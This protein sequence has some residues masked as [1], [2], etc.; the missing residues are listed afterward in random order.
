MAMKRL[1]R[2]DWMV[3]H[4]AATKTGQNVTVDDIRKWHKDRGFDDIGY[5]YYINFAGEVFDGRSIEFQGAHCPK[6]NDRSIGVCLEGGYGG[7]NNF[8]EEQMIAVVKLFEKQRMVFK[9]IGISGHNQF[10][11]SKT[12]PVFNPT[13]VWEQYLISKASRFY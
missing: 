5:H 11:S 8:K 9:N 12:C 6:V 13:E 10:N 2:V 1:T 3:V 7:V 4:C